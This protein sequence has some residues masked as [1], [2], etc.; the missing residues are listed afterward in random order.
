M[1]RGLGH[2]QSLFR[3]MFPLKHEYIIVKH[4]RQTEHATMEKLSN[5]REKVNAHFA[6]VQHTEKFWKMFF[7]TFQ[8]GMLFFSGRECSSSV[9]NH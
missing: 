9:V 1:G 7:Q 2:V 8:A 3:S 4:K 6:F 5:V